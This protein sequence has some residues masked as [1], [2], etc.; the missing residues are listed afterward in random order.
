MKHLIFITVI[1]SLLFWNLACTKD[2]IDKEQKKEAS[3]QALYIEDMYIPDWGRD[4]EKAPFGFDGSWTIIDVFKPGVPQ[5]A[6]NQNPN[7]STKIEIKK[8][9]LS[10][11]VNYQGIKSLYVTDF[12]FADSTKNFTAKVYWDYLNGNENT[13]YPNQADSQLD[14]SNT[15]EWTRITRK[16]K[17][18]DYFDFPCGRHKKLIE[19]QIETPEIDEN[20][21]VQSNRCGSNFFSFKYY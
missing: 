5:M 3:K 14:P 20:H 19:H 21:L 13:L 1:F 18:A 4:G 8:V 11:N 15:N 6:I 17:Y 2:S 9:P 12:F 7:I 10:P 16:S